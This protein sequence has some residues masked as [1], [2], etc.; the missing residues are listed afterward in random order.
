ML[1]IDDTWTSGGHAQSA[2]LALRQA[3]ATRISALI[4]A[5]WLTDDLGIAPRS[6]TPS[7]PRFD[8]ERTGKLETA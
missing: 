4:V 7:A 1:L 6:R 3:G 8:W 5:R 2:A